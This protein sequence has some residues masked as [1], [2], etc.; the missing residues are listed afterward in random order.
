MGIILDIVPNH[1]AVMTAD[2]GW[3]LDVLEDGPASR[4]ADYFDIDWTP[5]RHSMRNRILVPAL[6]RPLG[7]AI[8]QG[9]VTLCFEP[10]KGAFF[11]A[12][13]GL[14]FPM[15]PA[16]YPLL[17]REI[18]GIAGAQGAAAEFAGVLNA[19][20]ALPGAQ[21]A[22]P[23]VLARRQRDK[24]LV[25]KRFAALCLGDPAVAR[26]V[27]AG[28]AAINTAA[29]AERTERVARILAAQPYRLAYWRVAGEE[30][31]YRR[32]FDVDALA[33]LRMEDPEV[34]E[35][36]HGL[37]LDLW[38]K[39]SID[40]L[41]I[42]HADGLYRPAEYLQRLRS[43][44]TDGR[45]EPYI[46][47]EKILE[48]GEQLP[49][50][51]RVDGTTG[52]EFGALLTAWLM[53]PQG[54]QR[55]ERIHDAFVHPAAPFGEIVYESKKRV[56]QSSLAAEITML[57]HRLDRIAQSSHS[58]ADFTLFDLRQAVVEVI[59]GFPV[60]RT[61][62]SEAGVSDTDAAIIRRAVG[63]ALGRK[64]TARRAIE[65]L[66]AVLLGENE[67]HQRV[68][69]AR[70]FCLRFQQVT[71]PVMAKGVEDTAFYR[72]S[73]LLPLNEVGADPTCRGVSNEMFHRANE[74][75]A[76]HHPRTLLA[77]STHDTKR[78]E[79]ARFRLCVLSEV[80]EVW[81]ECLGRWR[82][83]K[84]RAMKEVLPEP[85]MEYLLLQ[86]ALSVWPAAGAAATGR[87]L[88]E[89]LADYAVKAGR[90]AK[91][92]TSW[93][94]PDP[95]YEELLR[96]YVQLLEPEAA[97][98]GF[99]RYFKPVIE[100][101]SYF[102]ALN[103]VVAAVAKFTVPGVPDIYQGNEALRLVMVDP[104][105]RDAIDL[106]RYHQTLEELEDLAARTPLDRVAGQLLA[107]CEDGRL[108]TFVTWRL[109][110]LRRAEADLFSRGGYLPIP[111]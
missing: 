43:L 95:D 28:L 60:Y 27:A 44:L 96:R 21:P 16:S 41:R 67:M 105:N 58:T 53:D 100:L 76:E 61:Y 57:A 31:N 33:A 14:Q 22:A 73:R 102:G 92:S 79:D 47:V 68:P 6:E 35:R 39:G 97:E 106:Q 3:W 83:L 64:Q 94:D 111:V 25:K 24:E 85:E 59:A 84:R 82:R 7:D 90:E 54:T 101:A 104:D 19:F 29:A 78:G 37:I 88:A 99:S 98:K 8:A 26:H 91:M 13:A 2:N 48:Q 63:A 103:S 38:R 89:R 1:M 15:D 50:D 11:V 55:L 81:W 69:A 46:V 110:T 32:F 75:R 4:Y 10:E 49:V 12:C 80:P 36:T 72:Y 17:L 5:A 62:I 77:T 51:W 42:D 109:L 56:M 86:T 30:I 87:R 93:L 107:C 108:K 74:R 66:G 71:G 65:Y 18:G 45:Q 52:Y 34:F 20:D 9:D 40:G 70:D 23:E